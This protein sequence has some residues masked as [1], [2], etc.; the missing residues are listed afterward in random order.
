MKKYLL[1]RI[2]PY[3]ALDSDLESDGGTHYSA[4]GEGEY[5]L[6]LMTNAVID[7]RHA[8]RLYVAIQAENL[9][10]RVFSYDQQRETSGS[11]PLSALGCSLTE[12][13]TPEH[14]D[15]LKTYLPQILRETGQQ[16]ATKIGYL[17]QGAYCKV[18]TFK[19]DKDGNQ[20]KVVLEPRS[21][22]YISEA[23]NKRRFFEALYPGQGVSL[24]IFSN[25]EGPF[26]YRLVLPKITGIPYAILRMNT[27]QIQQAVFKSCLHA[28][29]NLHEKGY[30]YVDLKGDNI[31]FDCATRTSSL[32]DGGQATKQ[33][34]RL[35]RDA[36]V[37]KNQALVAANRVSPVFA[38]I[39]PECW[40]TVRVPAKTSMDIYSL[41]RMLERL[42]KPID[43]QLKPLIDSCLN[44]NPEDRPT[45]LNLQDQLDA[46]KFFTSTVD[47]WPRSLFSGSGSQCQQGLH[48]SL[49]GN[50]GFRKV[51]PR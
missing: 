34:S 48:G 12:L 26:T 2:S 24:K 47:F 51:L 22:L 3:G 15:Q 45:L 6:S 16:N 13:N 50:E 38:H 25:E 5:R 49:S 9:T 21:I 17:G 30:V 29:A 11:I 46:I 33:G 40:D 36:F 28:L 1:S 44:D 18:R 4:K 37:Q 41:G 14:L 27:S 8:G 32:V 31:L 20:P 39:A 35:D 10:Y 43:P 42:F 23:R 7:E 19:P